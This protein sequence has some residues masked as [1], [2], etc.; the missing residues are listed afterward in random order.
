V[1][2][3]RLVTCKLDLVLVTL[4]IVSVAYCDCE[5][6]IPGGFPT[7]RYTMQDRGFIKSGAEVYKSVCTAKDQRGLQ[8]F[9]MVKSLENAIQ[10]QLRRL[11]VRQSNSVTAL[12]GFL[13]LS[14]M[15]PLV[16][17]IQLDIFS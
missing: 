7:C 1:L 6:V 14:N 10:K 11:S 8:R 12:S 5:S 13:P 9:W 15:S 2:S 17:G 3:G 4:L 16:S